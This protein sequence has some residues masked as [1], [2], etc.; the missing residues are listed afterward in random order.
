M[1]LDD[2]ARFPESWN[3]FGAS[4]GPWLARICGGQSTHQIKRPVKRFLVMS[5]S[6]TGVIECNSAI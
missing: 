5:E 6:E 1:S 2:M 4:D 3:V